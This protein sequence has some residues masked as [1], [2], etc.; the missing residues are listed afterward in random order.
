MAWFSGS[1]VLPCQPQYELL[2]ALSLLPLNNYC[3]G[4]SPLPFFG[5]T[6]ILFTGNVLL[7]SCMNSKKIIQSGLLLKDVVHIN[8][9]IQW[10][11]RVWTVSIVA[12]LA[13]DRQSCLC[14]TGTAEKL[15]LGQT[16]ASL[17][18]SINLRSSIWG[19]RW[20]P[21]SGITALLIVCCL[22]G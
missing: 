3:F 21:E 9:P 6:C 14:K 20:H 12:H 15:L 5:E 18:K 10:A 8:M 1:P 7:I 22:L 17:G 4:Y 16:L 19:K 2:C 11:W 13:N